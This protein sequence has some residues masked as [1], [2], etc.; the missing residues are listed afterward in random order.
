MRRFE[1]KNAGLN[2]VT[3]NLHSQPRLPGS[4]VGEVSM[5]QEQKVDKITPGIGLK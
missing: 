5:R 2:V 1:A 3:L 4:V